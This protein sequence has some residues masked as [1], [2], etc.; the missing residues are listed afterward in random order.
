MI[1]K[2]GKL[3]SEINFVED[4]LLPKKDFL[5]YGEINSQ[6]VE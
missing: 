2:K 4:N 3:E 6:I 5:D 1:P